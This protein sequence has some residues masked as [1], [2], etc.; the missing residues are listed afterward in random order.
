MAEPAIRQYEPLIG[1]WRTEGEVLDE[2]GETVAEIEGRDLYDW[3][4]QTFVVHRAD[5]SMGGERGQVVEIFGPYLEADRAFATRAYG[6]DGSEET[7]TSTIPSD[8]VFTFGTTGARAT[9][10]VAEDGRTATAEWIRTDDSGA[11]WRPWMRLRFT[12]IDAFP[13]W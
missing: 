2:D 12:R 4:G 1:T 13:L 5:V 6:S 10:E 9:M 8:R 3:L 11:T 7:S